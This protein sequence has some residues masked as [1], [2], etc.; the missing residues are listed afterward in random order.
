MSRSKPHI[1]ST[2][3]RLAAGGAE[4]LVFDLL[5]SRAMSQYSHTVV[6]LRPL[7]GEFVERYCRAGINIVRCPLRWPE[8]TLFR[9]TRGGRLVRQWLKTF[10]PYRFVSVLR[11]LNADLVH[12]HFPMDVALQANGAITL[13]KLPYVYTAHGLVR[14][15]PASTLFT[16]ATLINSARAALVAISHAVL[17]SWTQQAQFD[18]TRQYVIHNGIRLEDF[19]P[20]L[21][22]LANWRAQYG[23]QEN[24]LLFGAAG[25]LTWEKGY[26]YLIRAAASLVRSC[27]VH[28]I[29]AGEGGL[30]GNLEGMI[31]EHHLKGRFHLIGYEDDMQR[32]LREI[33]VLIVPSISEGFSLTLL[34]ACA[35]RLPC[36]ATR[37]G[38]IPEVAPNGVALLI[39]PGDVE[40]LIE[41]MQR[42]LSPG[43]RSAYAERARENSQNFS[44]EVTAQ[45]Y[46]ELY[47]SLL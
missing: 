30:R 41:A 26:E 34:E 14:S 47:Q 6:V 11:R 17:A 24:V 31:A 18:P 23:I 25:R 22:R 27:P 29:V 9:S 35:M 4:K 3:G 33:D 45:K 44:I 21:P 36:I 28:F 19:D 46:H 43:I 10:F 1:V 5:T 7:E 8:I 40:G 16:L 32:F 20:D 13:A 37:V 2:L 15:T 42:M 12:S 39:S 38:G